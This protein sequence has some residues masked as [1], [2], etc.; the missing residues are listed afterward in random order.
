VRVIKL[1]YPIAIG[2]QSSG[3]GELPL[4][5]AVDGSPRAD[6][7]HNL[8]KAPS[9]AGLQAA[10]AQ[11]IRIRLPKLPA[12]ISPSFLRQD[13]ATCGPQLFDVAGAE[14]APNVEP[15]RGAN[16]FC[17]EP[18]VLLWV[19]CAWWPTAAR[20]SHTAAARK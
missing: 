3:G 1:I 19:G 20:M 10:V 18:M 4:A 12:L 17:R 11:A 13:E 7:Q 14:V 15:H 16:G 2:K 6:G 5:F 8:I 9:V